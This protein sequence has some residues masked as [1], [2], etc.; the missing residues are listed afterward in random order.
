MPNRPCQISTDVPKDAAIELPALETTVS[1][2]TAI[3]AMM[4]MAMRSASTLVAPWSLLR[5]GAWPSLSA[6]SSSSLACI[7]QI[8]ISA[9]VTAVSRWP[10]DAVNRTASPSPRVPPCSSATSPRAT[11]KCR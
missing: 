6:Q 5:P 1:A 11:N 7:S 10:P 4:S 8:K 3:L 9:T 2:D